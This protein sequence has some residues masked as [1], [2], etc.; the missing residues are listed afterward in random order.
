MAS[1]GAPIV[2]GIH[3]FRPENAQ[4]QVM[5]PVAHATLDTLSMPVV[6]IDAVGGPTPVLA[7]MEPSDFGTPYGVVASAIGVSVQSLEALIAGVRRTADAFRWREPREANLLLASLASGLHLLTTLAEASAR[8]AGLDLDALNA[9]RPG[10]GPLDA[11]GEAL[12]RLGAQQFS[13][14]YQALAATLSDELAP[15]LCGWREIFAEILVHADF[16]FRERAAC[17]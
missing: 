13:G 11:M 6:R 5:R 14:D 3:R 1:S 15:A 12:D 2:S 9:R 10:G 7:P 8:A 17:S 16:K 4:R